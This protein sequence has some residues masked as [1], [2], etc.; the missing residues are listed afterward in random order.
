[1]HRFFCDDAIID[2][3]V[4]I[5]G[6]DYKHI[7]KVLRISENERIEVVVSGKLYNGLVEFKDGYVNIYDLEEIVD[8]TESSINIYLLQCLVKGDKLDYIIQKS[9]ELG[10]NGIYLINSLRCVVKFDNKKEKVKLERFNRISYEA[11]KQ[12][13][14]LF[15][16][17][18]N[19]VIEIK[20]IEKFL[21]KESAILIAYENDRNSSLREEIKILKENNIKN[22]YVL[23]GSE[24]G[25]EKSEVE[26]LKSKGAKTVGLGPRILRTETA[27]ISLISILQYEYM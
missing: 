13:K 27:G 17:E 24:G 26:F 11:S 15:V 25:L 7:K 8:N 14:R 23:I 3:S 5:S 2:N 4:K 1:M 9:V 6:Y 12:S 22:I 19:G 10:V 21:D 18:V 20:D 16:P